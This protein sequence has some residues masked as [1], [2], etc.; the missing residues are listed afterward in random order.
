MA[1]KYE[2][3]GP[4]GTIARTSTTYRASRS[5]FGA[6]SCHETQIFLHGGTIRSQST[7][8]DDQLLHGGTIQERVGGAGSEPRLVDSLCERGWPEDHPLC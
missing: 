2:L 4:F 5:Y 3:E 1:E 7:S 6:I 8:Y